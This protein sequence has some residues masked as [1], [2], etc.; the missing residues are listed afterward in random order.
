MKGLS[1]GAV[2]LVL[3]AAAS[4]QAQGGPSFDCAKA[5]N[6]VERTICK[7]PDLARAD[8]TMAARYTALADRLS[9]PA[10]EHLVKSQQHWVVSRNRACTGDTD[11]IELC[12]QTRYGDRLADLAAAGAGTYPFVSGR[13][14]AKA[15]KIG[16]VTYKI[17]IGYPHFDGMSADFSAVNRSFADDAAA[18]ARSG[19]PTADLGLDRDQ[20]WFSEQNYKLYRPGPDAIL[21]ALTSWSFTG[22]A[23]GNGG[24]VCSLVDLGTGR[25]V[26]PDGVFA[27]GGP[28]LKQVVGIV[29]ADLKKQFVENPGFDDALEPA[30]LAEILRDGSHYCWQADKLELYFNQY[31]IGPYSA[32]PYTVDIPYAK[33]KPLLRNGGLIAP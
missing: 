18:S 2:L 3:I 5:S 7:K 27:A 25:M 26:G 10:R 21:V 24:T 14:I 13:E 1:G 9:G 30:K 12:L 17:D 15:G 22:G 28:W 16:R 23:H 31:E 20:E 11:A 19:T 33:L 4:A 32:G 8:R 29:G 6:A